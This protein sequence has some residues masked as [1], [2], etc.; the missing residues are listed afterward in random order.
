MRRETMKQHVFRDAEF[1][2]AREKELA[3]KAWVRFLKNGLRFGDFRRRLYDHLHLHCQ[4]IAHYNRLGFYQTYFERGEDALRFLSQFDGRGE[5]RSVEYGMTIW[6]EGDYGDLAKAMIEETAPYIPNLVAQAQARERE[7]DLGEAKR[8]LAKHGRELPSCS[9][10]LTSG[11]C[12]QRFW[13]N[14]GGRI[15]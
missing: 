7:T 3:L 5:C 14:G 15:T 1:M 13:R 11:A 9:A 10:G 6:R 4:F 12:H 8:L 2:T